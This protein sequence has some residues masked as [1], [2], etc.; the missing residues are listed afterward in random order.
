MH[1]NFSE[2]SLERDMARPT[3]SWVHKVT[4]LDFRWARGEAVQGSVSFNDP[5][6]AIRAIM[7]QRSSE[8]RMARRPGIEPGMPLWQSNTLTTE[9]LHGSRSAWRGLHQM[10]TDIILGMQK[11]SQGRNGYCAHAHTIASMK[12][13]LFKPQIG[14]VVVR[15]DKVNTRR[16]KKLK[17]RFVNYLHTC[18]WTHHLKE[19]QH[20]HLVFSNLF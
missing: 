2:S 7:V 19:P 3:P 18:S 16:N 9:P 4:K 6:Y 8:Q 17:A 13:V 11:Y 15:L 12:L 14:S 5:S 1:V 20:R 10:S